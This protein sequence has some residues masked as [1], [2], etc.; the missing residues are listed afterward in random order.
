[1]AEAKSDQSGIRLEIYSTEP[2]VQFYT[3]QG[4]HIKNG[5]EGNHYGPFAGF[6]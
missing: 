1:V 5:K 3:G 2:A 4:L 6:V